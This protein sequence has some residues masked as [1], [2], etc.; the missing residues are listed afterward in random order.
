MI[1]EVKVDCLQDKIV[2]C[3]KYH[4]GEKLKAGVDMNQS[5]SAAL[6]L[7]PKEPETQYIL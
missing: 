7:N 6:I 4:Q 5:L 2:E 3:V 1:Q